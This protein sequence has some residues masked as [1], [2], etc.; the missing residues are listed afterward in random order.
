RK[1][2]NRRNDWP[3]GSNADCG[4]CMAITTAIPEDRPLTATEVSLVR[5]LL[6]HGIPQAANYIPQLDRARVASRCYCGCASVD[7]AI[8]GAVPSASEPMGVLAD[9]E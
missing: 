5:W 2:R 3:K 4:G 9:F 1:R 6:Q 8:D 7:F